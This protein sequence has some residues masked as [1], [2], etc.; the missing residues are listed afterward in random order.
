MN[1]F[2]AG[3]AHFR[4]KTI[5]FFPGANNLPGVGAEPQADIDAGRAGEERHGAVVC[6]LRALLAGCM[7]RG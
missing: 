5:V 3:L 1:G 4:Y 2:V 7:G 6:W